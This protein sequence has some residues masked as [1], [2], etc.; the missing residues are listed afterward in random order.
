M[1][2]RI[3]G[4][5]PTVI[6]E[7]VGD[8]RTQP[9][10]VRTEAKQ[11]QTVIGGTTAKAKED[12][13]PGTC[14][15]HCHELKIKE[16]SS[17]GD[18]CECNANEPVRVNA[19]LVFTANPGRVPVQIQK[20]SRI[21]TLP[22]A[23]QLNREDGSP[24]T[25]LL[26]ETSFKTENDGEKNILHTEKCPM[27]SMA[28]TTCLK[29]ETVGQNTSLLDSEEGVSVTS[30]VATKRLLETYNLDGLKS[31]VVIQKLEELRHT[32]SGLR[33]LATP[34]PRQVV[35]CISARSHHEDVGSL[36]SYVGRTDD[37]LSAKE[38]RSLPSNVE[39][40]P[41]SDL[42]TAAP[43]ASVFARAGYHEG[44][45]GSQRVC[46]LHGSVKEINL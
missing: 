17:G 18:A 4:E 16:S 24:L 35:T 6:D 27:T 44:P 12:S 23:V 34:L 19:R 21:R 10:R 42:H 25:S 7:V 5:T 36:P 1:S 33:A 30:T 45:E 46:Q 8:S 13:T 15:K 20:E 31:N 28:A 37:L 9:D 38:S 11:T 2:A 3:K 43:A 14:N 32:P 22:R 29:A 26:Y 40:R 39:L 41:A